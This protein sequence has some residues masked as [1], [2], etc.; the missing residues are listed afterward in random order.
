MRETVISTIEKEKIIAIVRGIE[1]EKCLKVAQALYDGGNRKI[2]MEA[3]L[4]IGG[5]QR[6]IHNELRFH[7]DP[8]N[9]HLCMSVLLYN[10]HEQKVQEQTLIDQAEHDPLTGLDNRAVFRRKAEKLLSEESSEGDMHA[11]M[12]IDLDDFTQ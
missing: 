2:T 10:I 11:L 8:S 9:G 1:P 7:V 5:I 4:D 12:L 6:W 3:E